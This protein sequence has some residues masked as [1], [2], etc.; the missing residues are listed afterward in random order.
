MKTIVF[1]G[2]GRIGQ[3][4]LNKLLDDQMPIVATYRTRIPFENE[5]VTW[6]QFDYEEKSIEKLRES[7]QQYQIT[8]AITCTPLEGTSEILKA[9]R[10][11]GIR[12][13]FLGSARKF[14]KIADKSVDKVKLAVS[15]AEQSNEDFLFIHPTMIYG[16]NGENN[17]HRMTKLIKT[18]PIIPMP[19]KGNSLIQ[20]IFTDDVAQALLNGLKK[21]SLKG[22]IIVPG[23]DCLE[24]RELIKTLA[25]LMDKR[26]FI[27]NFPRLFI[28]IA[29]FIT[30]I[31]PFLPE[32][33][34]QE[35]ERLYEDKD[36]ECEPAYKALNI[37]PTPLREGL[38]KT[39]KGL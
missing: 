18:F 11:L 22:E 1:G 17:I 29:V 5:N 3:V 21:T 31:I 33:G 7:L 37:T 30:R 19:K 8:S 24:Y 6:I 12:N 39:L 27:T 35:I 20:P 32:I 4:V 38:T 13:I 10:G 23:P 2:S 14:S 25:D 26:V 28:S 36:F 34:Y 15:Y 9:V 16:R